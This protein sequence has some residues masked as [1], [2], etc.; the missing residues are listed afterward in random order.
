M[1][2]RV[3]RSLKPFRTWAADWRGGQ[4]WSI[5][6]GTVTIRLMAEAHLVRD[7]FVASALAPGVIVGDAVACRVSG[8]SP[9]YTITDVRAARFAGSGPVDQAAS[10]AVGTF[11]PGH[12]DYGLTSESEYWS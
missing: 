5:S 2:D 12:V 3:A 11:T 7:Y 4:I 1:S 9:N 8:T 6:G 10:V